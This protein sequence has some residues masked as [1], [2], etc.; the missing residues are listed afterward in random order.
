M[1][2]VRS[3]VSEGKPVLRPSNSTVRGASGRCVHLPDPRLVLHLTSNASSGAHSRPPLLR[4]GC[5]G[6]GAQ[7]RRACWEHVPSA[8]SQRHLPRS[9]FVTPGGLCITSATTPRGPRPQRVR[10]PGQLSRSPAGGDLTVPGT[11]IPWGP[12]KGVS[13][14]GRFPAYGARPQTTPQAAERQALPGSKGS[15]PPRRGAKSER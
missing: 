7:L 10:N 12:Q 14:R 3:W 1:P 5:G 4:R 9:S 11:S 6:E 2:G 15:C 8:V 13:G